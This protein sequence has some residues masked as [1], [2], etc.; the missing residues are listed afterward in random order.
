MPTVFLRKLL[1][2]PSPSQMGRS[3]TDAL[4]IRDFGSEEGD[5]TW[6]DWE[7]EVA[8]LFPVRFFIA[9]KVGS[10]L[11][12]LSS[13]AG[14]ALYWVQCHTLPEYRGYSK[15]D[16]SQAGP[17]IDYKYGWLDRSEALLY[18]SF[19]CLRQYIEN[20]EPK[21]PAT[22]MTAEELT[23][24]A[25]KAQKDNFDE[26]HTLYNWWMKGRME[27]EAKEKQLREEAYAHS[28]FT[29]EGQAASKV[30]L[31]YRHWQ[32]ERE[33]EMLM[34]LVKIRNTLWT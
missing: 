12:R 3:E 15:I 17:G 8:T 30:W 13:R 11:G 4:P 29:P 18:A 20:E 6:E 21:D 22:F 16:L 27:E 10:T 24:P 32:S 23:E 26:A 5:Y 2:I 9:E 25:F 1:Q 33:D 19:I 14:D 28:R 34:R 7:E 31:D